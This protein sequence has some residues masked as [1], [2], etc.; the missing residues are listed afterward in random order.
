M[1]EDRES[2]RGKAITRAV[3]AEML[4]QNFE[5]LPDIDKKLFKYGS[6][7]FG[8]NAGLAGLVANSLYRRALNVTQVRISAN[9]PMAVLPFVTTVAV[10]D[11]VVSGPLLAGDLNCP[12]CALIR[13]TLVGV[14]CGA[15]YPTLLALP[16]NFYLATRYNTTLMP[17]TGSSVMRHWFDVSRPI[18]RKMRVVVV[19]Q[20]FFGT[21]LGSRHFESYSKLAEITFGRGEE[22]KD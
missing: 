13:G 12:S 21:Y 17:E 14:L 7:Y 15:L 11:A 1:S 5:R 10:Y 3:I 22:H 20:A 19:L 2:V 8:A 18:L 4:S 16:L 9:L 6:V